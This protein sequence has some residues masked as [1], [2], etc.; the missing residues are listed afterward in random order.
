[1]GTTPEFRQRGSF[2]P[3]TDMV[4]SGPLL[5]GQWSD[6]TSMALCLAASLVERQGFDARDRMERYCRWAEQGYMSS[7]GSCF[8]IGGTTS[9]ALRRSRQTRDP[10][11]G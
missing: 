11:A 6:D 8:D 4:G 9:A 5:P 10:F 7:T 2:E 1:M 3:P